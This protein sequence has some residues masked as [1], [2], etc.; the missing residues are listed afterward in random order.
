MSYSETSTSKTKPPV[1]NNSNPLLNTFNH[2]N[3]TND[4]KTSK[5]PN[6][7]LINNGSAKIN[8]NGNGVNKNGANIQTQK[9]NSQGGG[10][11]EV[12]HI[13][14]E[15][16][17]INFDQDIKFQETKKDD[18]YNVNNINFS[19]IQFHD[20]INTVN[21]SEEAKST[22]KLNNNNL[23]NNNNNNNNL[24]NNDNSNELLFGV[25]GNITSESKLPK[26]KENITNSPQKEKERK[27]DF[28]LGSLNLDFGNNNTN[29][30]QST[31]KIDEKSIPTMEESEI[32]FDLPPLNVDP[33]TLDS[34]NIREMCDPIVNHWAKGDGSE[35]KNIRMLLSTLN[36]IWKSKKWVKVSLGDV[37]DDKAL[38]KIYNKSIMQIHPDK[39]HSKD[40]RMKYCAERV[41]NILTD[42]NS[43]NKK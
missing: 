17:L 10:Q 37:L 6:K 29:N 40:P 28:D 30:T 8:E 33:S 3:V 20:D 38:K 36:D 32:F 42:A 15:N 7:V 4:M 31:G 26:A 5:S 11:K 34:F 13:V 22:V 25:F 9:F 23:I 19:E 16:N 41:C 12:I 2:S 18:P 27:S 1:N 35:K 21:G 24:I 43:D 39:I 14:K